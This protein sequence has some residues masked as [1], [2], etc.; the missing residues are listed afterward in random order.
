MTKTLLILLLSG[1]STLFGCKPDMRLINIC[2]ISVTNGS[3]S[4]ARADKK[5]ALVYPEKMQ[6]WRAF[7]KVSMELLASRLEECE[8]HGKLPSSRDTIAEMQICVVSGSCAPLIEDGYFA[9]DLDG[10][11]MIR[12]K[13]EFCGETPALMEDDYAATQNK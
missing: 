3:A 11:S 12:S 1:C 6:T 13:L 7:S 10:M 5:F 8:R 4:C 9:T 2:R